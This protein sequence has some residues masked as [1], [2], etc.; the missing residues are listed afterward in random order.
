MWEHLGFL[1]GGG[2]LRKG[3]LI[4]KRGGHALTMPFPSRAFLKVISKRKLT[5][6]FIFTLLCGAK[7]IL[8][9][10]KSNK[11]VLCNTLIFKLNVIM[12]AVVKYK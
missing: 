9:K 7:N 2:D 5:E 11:T 8:M 6:I 4:W 3:V 10:R 12:I 1:E